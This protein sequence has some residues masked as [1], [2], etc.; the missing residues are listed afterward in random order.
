MA[1]IRTIKPEFFSHEAIFDA[2]L[3]SGLPLR[4]AFVGLWTLCDREGRFKWEPRRLKLGCLP[5]D[6]L[7]FA[8]VLDALVTR[9]FV[10]KYTVA[11]VQ[12]GCVPGLTEHQV[13]NPRESASKLPGS[14]QADPEPEEKPAVAPTV[15]RYDASP[16][17]EP[18]VID[19]SPTRDA[20]VSDPA[21]G[22]GKGREHG[23]GK[24]GESATQTASPSLFAPIATPL[25]FKK[26]VFA[27]GVP[28]IVQTDGVSEK[29]ARS[30][31]GRWRSDFGDVEV[32]NALASAQGNAV[33]G[34]IP[35]V[36]KILRGKSNGRS[37]Q[38]GLSR[39]GSDHP[40]GAFAQ[41]GDEL[42]EVPLAN[43]RDDHGSAT[44]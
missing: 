9:G 42:A 16:T 19:A 15:T 8:R 41:L 32:L 14:D 38:F 43:G 4:I 21:R 24:E 39:N 7:D 3:E 11:G 1:R 26:Q 34:V 28:L 27:S 10:V 17:R 5:Y 44:H 37:R 36:Q 25:D 35:Y 2:E 20:P 13:F 31:L 22:E 29:D 23:T 30:M 6:E 33:T 12:Y 18:R 40:L